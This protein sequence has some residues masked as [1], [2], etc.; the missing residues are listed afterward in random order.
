MAPAIGTEAIALGV[1]QALNARNEK[2]RLSPQ[3]ALEKAQKDG[4]KKGEILALVALA[5]TL[6]DGDDA[7]KK[8][9]SAV[10][11]FKSANDKSGEA[12]ALIV[13]AH[14]YKLKGNNGEGLKAAREA[15]MIFHEVAD[16]KGEVTARDTCALLRPKV[17]KKAPA[18]Q[19][20]EPPLGVKKPM[21]SC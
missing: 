1:A 17:E 18:E 8:A 9:E 7:L 16:K 10:A 19:M 12:S 20:K 15:L 5:D 13:K 11:H 4:D 21:S 6:K 2:H 3:A 14:A